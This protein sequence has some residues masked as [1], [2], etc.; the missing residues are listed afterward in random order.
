[1]RSNSAKLLNEYHRL[2]ERFRT[3]DNSSKYHALVTA[4]GNREHPVQ[5][6]FHLK[7]AF[8]L[9]LLQTLLNDWN[10]SIDSINRVLDPFC[11]I[12]TSLLSSQM[13]AKRYG[14]ADLEAVGIERNPFLHFVSDAK[15]RWHEY[16]SQR[17]E[18][19]V[20]HL[21]N[22]GT[23]P[24]VSA[25]P[26]L[27]TLH[28][29]EVYDSDI[30]R[31]IL[32][33]KEAIKGQ[34]GSWQE[35]KLLLL[36]YAAVLE[37]LSGVRKDGRALRIVRDKHRPTVKTALRLKWHS[38]MEDLDSAKQHYQPVST[39]VVLGDG[40]TLTG[41]AEAAGDLG[42][43]DLIFYSPPYLNNIDYT[44][45]YKIELWMSGFVNSA[46]EF[47]DLRFNTFRSH[48]SVRFPDPITM[49]E[50]SDMEEFGDM[51]DAVVGALPADKNLAWRSKLFRGYFDDIY[52][53]LKHQISVLNPGG[54]VFC[55]V[56]NSLHGSQSDLTA[57]VPVASDLLISLIAESLGWD[58]RAV[59]VARHLKRRAPGGEYLRESIL[60]L[61]KPA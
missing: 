60:V 53:S 51:I 20:N 15:L 32:A 9:H 19:A 8:S 12:G 45:V 56:G 31:R 1:M 46:D 44:E 25:L 26:S 2:E 57:R 22:G 30:L 47:R 38:L 42:M 14:K 52:V 3:I 17:V 11:G 50:D 40:R 18:H 55:V 49:L 21:L 13:L 39:R 27:S 4:N 48:P 24:Y 34:F 10:T 35:W 29:R 7:E 41:E 59:Q 54:W 37:A 33:F 61:Q 16:E 5:R 28:R 6:W 58:V 43:F 23:K 36:G